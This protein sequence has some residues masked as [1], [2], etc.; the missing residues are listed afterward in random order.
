[1]STLIPNVQLF[2]K[3]A[4]ANESAEQYYFIAHHQ[5]KGKLLVINLVPIIIEYQIF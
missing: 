2:D 4:A 3:T 5:F 1:M